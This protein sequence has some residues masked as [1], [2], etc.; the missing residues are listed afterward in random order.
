LFVAPVGILY[1]IYADPSPNE[2]IYASGRI[3]TAFQYAYN[4]PE[5]IIPT[6]FIRAT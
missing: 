1:A 4:A 5:M 6:V 2:C 3:N